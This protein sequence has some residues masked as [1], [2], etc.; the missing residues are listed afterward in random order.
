MKSLLKLLAL[1]IVCSTSA[2]AQTSVPN[3][4]PNVDPMRIM[5]QS[6]APKPSGQ[7]TTD[8]KTS[9]PKSKPK[10]DPMQ[11]MSK[12]A[13][14]KPALPKPSGQKTTDLKNPVPN[15]KPN[16]DPMRIMSQEA[17][18][19]SRSATQPVSPATGLPKK[20]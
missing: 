2:I 16:V 5:S 4:K 3:S 8:L 13:A 18:P 6:A 10:V 7:K 15:S 12:E 14:L 9:V 11:I 17:A 1:T 20:K 19:M